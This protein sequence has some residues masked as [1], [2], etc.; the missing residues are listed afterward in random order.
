M[1]LL[2]KNQNES[3]QDWIER[4]AI[5]KLDGDIPRSTTWKQIEDILPINY[6]WETLRKYAQAWKLSNDNKESKDSISEN[7][8]YKETTEMIEDGKFK[9][10]KMIRLLDN[11]VNDPESMLKAHGY[12]TEKWDLIKFKHSAWNAQ[13]KGGGLGTL[14]SSQII[15][16]PKSNKFKMTD[17]IDII[18]QE[19]VPYDPIPLKDLDYNEM[20]LEISLYDLHFGINDMKYYSNTFNNICNI[21]NNKYKTIVIV[22]GQDLIHN[23]NFRGT[24][25]KGTPIDKV[26]M[27]K[28]VKEATEFY[29][30]MIL[31]ALNGKVENIHI[32]F[33]NGNHDE[34]VGWMIVQSLMQRFYNEPRVTFDDKMKERKAF[35]WNDIF[36][37]FTHADKSG[38]RTPKAFEAEYKRQILEAKIVEFHSGHLHH[39]IVKDESGSVFRT[40]P[41]GAETD[42]YHYDKG[43]MGANKRFQLFEYSKDKLEKIYYVYV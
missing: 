5:S 8:K 31:Y 29:I 30:S 1:N 19:I 38:S 34:T 35:I 21:I 2:A 18:K 36:I 24:T 13:R 4:I 41:T 12:D 6:G 7:V 40:L 33:S 22:I 39:E 9:S 15:V 10:D 23:D 42:D 32:I 25:T 11:E 27:E 26:H 20:L 3:D 16:S 43:L 17:L 14:Y 37:G 28:A